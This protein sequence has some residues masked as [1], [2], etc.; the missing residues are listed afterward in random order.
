M[1]V[2]GQQ[3]RPVMEPYPKLQNILEAS[4]RQ[5]ALDGSMLL[6]HELSLKEAEGAIGTKQD[7]AAGMENAS[8]V[9][10]VKSQEEY[11]GTFY[12]VFSLR[13]AIVLGSLLLGVPLARV[14][15]KKK[16]AIIDSDDVD[17]FSEFTN[18]VIGSFNPVFKANLAGKI[19]LK[20]LDPKKFIPGSDAITPDMPLP[21]GDYFICRS[22]LEMPEQELDRIDILVPA[23]LASLIDPPEDAEAVPAEATSA[24]E[25]EEPVEARPACPA[26]EERTVLILEE[27]SADREFFQEA[28]ST[29]EIKTIAADPGADL[30]GFF[31]EPPLNAVI[32]G[33]NE[34]D[35]HEFSICVKIRTMSAGESVPVIMCAREWTRTGVLKAL[36]YG[37]KEIIMKPCTPDELR[38]KL[39]KLLEAA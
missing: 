8:F 27:N 31:P 19:H 3:I 33:V 6:G 37:A 16:L 22:Q 29:T 18:Q 38:G 24:A 39:L 23:P 17:A 14:S 10:G 2:E 13:D 11:D 25:E 28:L 21:D 7:Y 36:K 15:E 26:T 5:A 32:L 12:M 9:V 34:A 20:L 35:D 30:S 4:L 1:K